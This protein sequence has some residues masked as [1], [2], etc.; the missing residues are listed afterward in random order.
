MSILILHSSYADIRVER[1]TGKILEIDYEGFGG[2]ANEWDDVTRFDPET[3]ENVP[4]M[5]VL[6]VGFWAADGY[7]KPQHFTE[8][9]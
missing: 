8:S 9:V 4:E 1:E 6:D 7:Y 3:F 2:E 5:D